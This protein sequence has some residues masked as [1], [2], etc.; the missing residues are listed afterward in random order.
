VKTK[1]DCADMGAFAWGQKISE[2]GPGKGDRNFFWKAP[3]TN[4]TLGRGRMRQ[5]VPVSFSMP[6]AGVPRL[7]HSAAEVAMGQRFGVPAALNRSTR[8]VRCCASEQLAGS[9]VGANLPVNIVFSAQ[10]GF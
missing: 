2:L 7:L 5:D 4:R 8:V 1:L 10:R 3:G 6:Q 9:K